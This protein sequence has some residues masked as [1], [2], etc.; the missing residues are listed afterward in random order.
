M[1]P[2]R[3]VCLIHS[4]RPPS[5]IITEFSGP[6]YCFLVNNRTLLHT[7]PGRE[8]LEEPFQLFSSDNALGI[9]F[10]Y[11]YFFFLFRK[12]VFRIMRGAI[13]FSVLWRKLILSSFFPDLFLKVASA[14]FTSKLHPD[15]HLTYRTGNKHNI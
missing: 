7:L 15:A 5:P 1:T 6:M 13:T 12:L 3:R 10:F 11:F 2:K 4:I 9:K 14:G 8:Q